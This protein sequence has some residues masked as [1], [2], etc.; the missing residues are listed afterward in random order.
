MEV[1]DG[2]VV[3][4]AGGAVVEVAGCTVVE[5]AASNAWRPAEAAVPGQWAHCLGIFFFFVLGK[6]LH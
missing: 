1:A 6:I 4:V 5:V 2:V 3:E